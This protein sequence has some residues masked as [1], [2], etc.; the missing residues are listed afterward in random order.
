MSPAKSSRR[1]LVAQLP[2]LLLAASLG[3]SLPGAEPGRWSFDADRAGESPGGFTAGDGRW[4]G[5]AAADPLGPRLVRAARRVRELRRI[6]V[7][8]D[9]RIEAVR[10]IQEGSASSGRCRMRNL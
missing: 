7:A 5:G 6:H 10:E 9:A 4:Q 3:G 1:G 8:V 2:A